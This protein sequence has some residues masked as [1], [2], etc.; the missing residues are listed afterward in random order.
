M[1][2]L[3]KGVDMTTMIEKLK[4]LNLDEEAV[5]S[6]SYEE[7]TDVFVHNET[8]VETALEETSVL[9]AFSELITTPGLSVKTSYGCDVMETL[10]DS[11]LLEDY[12][13]DHS[14]FSEFVSSAIRENFYDVD[15]ID[16]SIEKY[17]Y[18]RGFCTLTADVKLTAAD[19]F[20]TSPHIE[21]WN[22][23]V[24]TDSGTLMLG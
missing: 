24:Q 14:G 18:K 5:V 11:D 17:D 20:R 7:G 15:L 21:G 9:D 8:E 2:N 19:I 10:R 13:R 3:Q 16:Y 22:V 12:P 4:N 23:S 6:L 1:H